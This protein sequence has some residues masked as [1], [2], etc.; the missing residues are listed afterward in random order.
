MMEVLT[1][2]QAVERVNT[3]V[4][5]EGVVLDEATIQ[6]VNV[7]DAM[8][9]S[10]GGII[11]PEQNIYYNDA[12]IEYDEDIDELVVTSGIVKLS[13]EEKAR[14]AEEFNDK[15][16][17]EK[18]SLIDLSTYKPEIDDWISANKKKLETLLRPIVINL[19]NAEKEITDWKNPP[20]KVQNDKAS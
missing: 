1:V 5:L 9:L 14:R 16:K 12:E 15:S 8:V 19:F 17:D 4:N 10:R 13:W 6:Q 18:K 3:G 7:R 20:N 2:K 11:I